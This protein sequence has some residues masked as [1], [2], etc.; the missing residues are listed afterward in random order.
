MGVH[1]MLGKQ[2]LNVKQDTI[3]V[4]EDK[5]RLILRDYLDSVDRRRAWI[6]PLGVAV[7]LFATLVTA[8]FKDVFLAKETWA[9]VF[10][11][12]AVASTLWFVFSLV[13]RPARMS[14]DDI[15]D[16]LKGDDTP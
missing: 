12:G 16:K 6:A 15:I 7:A 10:W 2:H 9:A 4:G 1:E 3:T 8:T 5:A 14:I 13:R 11:I